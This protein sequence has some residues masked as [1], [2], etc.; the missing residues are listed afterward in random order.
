MDS[1]NTTTAKM[2]MNKGVVL[3][4][5]IAFEQGIYFSAENIKF[6]QVHPAKTIQM[7]LKV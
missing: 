6:I 1:F 2:L 5:S 3:Q 7:K 4:A